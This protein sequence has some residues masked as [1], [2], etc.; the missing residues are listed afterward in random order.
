MESRNSCAPDDRVLCGQGDVLCGMLD[1]I[2]MT[3]GNAPVV[4]YCIKVSMQNVRKQTIGC[5]MS[6]RDL[7]MCYICWL[8]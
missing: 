2:P 7:S 8:L 1:C 5:S 4:Q 6:A 3:H